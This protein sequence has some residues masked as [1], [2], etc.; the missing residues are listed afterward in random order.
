[1]ALVFA[2]NK[3]NSLTVDSQSRTPNEEQ[4]EPEM[5]LFG[6]GVY[7]PPVATVP[8][9]YNQSL[10]SIVIDKVTPYTVHAI[11]ADRTSLYNLYPSEAK[12][13]ALNASQTWYWG[14][15]T[16]DTGPQH[17]HVY[18]RADTYD[19]TC[20]MDVGFR[21]GAIG[22]ITCEC[23]ITVL[24]PKPMPVIEISGPNQLTGSPTSPIEMVNVIATNTGGQ[25]AV[26]R[27]KIVKVGGTIDDLGWI[28]ISPAETI[29]LPNGIPQSFDVT[30]N[31]P[32]ANPGDLQ[33]NILCDWDVITSGVYLKFIESQTIMP[34][35]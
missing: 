29:I 17:S 31:W 21:G 7:Q 28:S 1:M 13:Y 8:A 6:V 20:I 3:T 32:Q 2:C 16:S 10:G 23:K 18:P 9:T 4:T 11:A 5:Q 22:R 30:L 26:V 35:Q 19:V 34:V 24:D 25:S 14:D 15:G 12:F 27:P 33:V